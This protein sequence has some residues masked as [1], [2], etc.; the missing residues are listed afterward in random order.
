MT[1]SFCG[2]SAF[3]SMGKN[4]AHINWKRNCFAEIKDE[5]W[6][7]NALYFRFNYKHIVVCS[8]ETALCNACD[9]N[10]V[11]YLLASAVYCRDARASVDSRIVKKLA[12]THTHARNLLHRSRAQGLPRGCNLSA[13]IK[14]SIARPASAKI[15]SS[16]NWQRA[17]KEM[18][19][20]CESRI[21]I[22]SRHAI[23][24]R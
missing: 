11:R 14:F 5:K 21:Q 7:Q 3:H 6:A 18:K 1:C 17:T 15:F 2:L 8:L 23:S 16:L 20:N 19:P 4:W 9:C 24:A 13:C 22:K 10:A 12:N